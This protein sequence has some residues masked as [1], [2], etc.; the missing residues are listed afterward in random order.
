M[1][2]YGI[3]LGPGAADLLTVRGKR[4]LEDVAVV[5]TP[6]RL[7]RRVA[8]EYVAESK[9]GDL[10][11]PMTRDPEE[12][13]RAW[14]EAADAVAPTALDADAAFVTLGDPCIYSTFGHLRR[15]LEREHSDVDVEVV[16]GVSSVTAFA[17]VFGVDIEAGEELC[18]REAA[19]G[20][21][22]TCPERM[23]LFKVTDVPTT[24]EKLTAAGYDVT[25][26][27]R[28]FMDDEDPLITDD[29]DEPGERDYYTLAYAVRS[30]ADQT[31]DDSPFSELA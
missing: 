14:R 27:R 3:G 16:P 6:G 25:F 13:R 15:T 28:L 26:G 4:V 9:L 17:S 7:S 20:A 18:L 10:D 24:H 19:D 12:L 2:L 21:A 30:D 29:P 22:P 11:F 1:T 5:Y 31:A 23:I 8:R